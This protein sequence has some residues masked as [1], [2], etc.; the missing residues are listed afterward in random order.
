MIRRFHFNRK[1]DVSGVSGT[2]RVCEGVQF[3]DGKCAVRW[4]TKTASLEVW[5]SVDEAIKVHGHG[6]ATE[7]VWDDE[8]TIKK[9]LSRDDLFGE[10]LAGETP[11]TIQLSKAELDTERREAISSLVETLLKSAPVYISGDADNLG[12]EVARVET[13]DDEEALKDVSARINAGQELFKRWIERLGG[14]VIE[15][16]GDEFLGKIAAIAPEKIEAFRTAYSKLVGATL[17]VG[18][19]N[20]ISEAT[21]AR[22]LGKLTGKDKVVTWTEACDKELRDKLQLDTPEATKLKDAGFHNL[23]KAETGPGSRGGH[24]IGSTPSGKPIYASAHHPAHEHFTALEH[25][26]AMRAHNAAAKRYPKDH[27]QHLHHLKQQVHHTYKMSHLDGSNPHFYI[28]KH[29]Y[30][31]FNKPL[32][33]HEE[34]TQEIDL[35]KIA[36]KSLEVT[37]LV[38][39]LEKAAPKG[40]GSR[41]GNVTGYTKDGKP[42]YNKLPKH[43]SIISAQVGKEH[44]DGRHQALKRDLEAHGYRHKEAKGKWGYEEKNFIV[45]HRGT[46][47]DHDRINALG[48]KH[49]QEAVF[50][51]TGNKNRVDFMNGSE[52]HHGEGRSHS[53]KHED[54]YT[55]WPDGRKFRFPVG[56]KKKD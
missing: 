40:P 28:P 26:H 55:H 22:L 18:V 37:Q 17:T 53:D 5:D 50:H 21:R 15:Q 42:V 16:G 31:A 56:E 4:L 23:T 49:G 38:E 29:Y 33:V 44:D 25:Y 14:E 6:G 1:Q 8:D 46:K 20:K 54:H 11:A 36:K 41:G 47:E 34:K 32:P 3:S 19:G 39:I 13:Q 10:L 2:G 27:P 12:N 43:F 24:I 51:R 30:H 9:S 52:S 35:N 48:K 45:H 7:L